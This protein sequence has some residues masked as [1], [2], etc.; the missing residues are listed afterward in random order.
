LTV[1]RTSPA[2]AAPT[3]V[4]ALEDEGVDHYAMAMRDPEG[5]EFDIN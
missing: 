4:K 1:T 5:N 3:I 2:S